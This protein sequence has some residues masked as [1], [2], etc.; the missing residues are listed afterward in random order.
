MI[1]AVYF[2]TNRRPKIC[3]WTWFWAGPDRAIGQVIDMPEL[4][5]T[6][7]STNYLA[8]LFPAAS[9]D[10][11][12]LFA[13]AAE[14]ANLLEADFQTVRDVLELAGYDG[15]ESL[16]VLLLDL[17]L[18]LEEGSLCVEASVPSLSRRLADLVGKAEAT[19][20]AER[21]LADL[22]PVGF[23]NL[24]GR[25]V[26][27]NRP[28]ILHSSGNKRFL[29]FQKYL[30][31]E[32][33]FQETLGKRLAEIAGM[34][35]PFQSALKEVLEEH[36]MRVGGRP[37]RLDSG[38][39]LALETALECNFA[40][41][42]GGPGTGKTSIV[43]T[44]LR[45]LV[46]LG[47]AP[48]RIALAAPTGRAAQRLGEAIRSGL[49]HLDNTESSPDAALAEV[50]PR[51][52]H[53]LL[54]YNPERGSYGRH[55]ENPIPADVVIIDEVS[56]VGLE[57]MSHLLQALAPKTKLILLGDKDQLPS[58]DAGAVLTNLVER[59]SAG[60]R[61]PRNSPEVPVV[62]L[63][64]NYR[65][66][67][68]IQEVARAINR[69]DPGIVEQLLPM[70]LAKTAAGYDLNPSLANL[71]KQ[72]G[73]CF[74]PQNGA[75][76]A[77]LR[78]IL[79]EFAKHQFL[80]AGP[81]LPSYHDLVLQCG[82]WPIAEGLP[83]EYKE[84]VDHLFGLLGR[85]RILTLVREGPWGCVDINRF[86]QQ[87]LR[88][89]GDRSRRVLFPG[90]P[91]LITRND[92]Q[93]QLFN[94]DVGITLART[95]GGLRVIFARSD[96]YATFAAD[97]LPPHELGFA[98]TVHKSQGSEYGQVLLILPPEGGRRLLTKEI[99]YTGITRAKQSA[100]IHASREA[101]VY[102]ISRNMERETGCLQQEPA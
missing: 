18:A 63:Q 13:A 41:I 26:R 97:A 86:L 59:A 75:N 20:W 14:N 39:K 16:H 38:Q 12:R 66:Q 49:G 79:Q 77:E 19:G 51:T 48:E 7:E 6:P 54:K 40:V 15:P 81:D 4:L 100:V 71:E 89:R 44:L 11:L 61:E 60:A 10:L 29:Y 2:S 102:A 3:G 92:H 28:V 87:Q 99:L 68:H 78:H 34:A 25:D 37:L 31:H 52:L 33:I 47:L 94:G 32:L 46:R 96:G 91:V 45:C 9:E 8:E 72:G 30:I 17:H 69:Q 101:L 95:G 53:Q 5:A 83:A 70:N 58:V 84:A 22:D 42:S 93:R 73:C 1:P 76:L 67:P 27:A 74:L 21:I 36:P 90:A 57:L 35:C 56:M 55:V 24:I 65:S 85:A 88:P 64:K 23:P 82:K 98:L 80:Q 43:L 62:V 50:A